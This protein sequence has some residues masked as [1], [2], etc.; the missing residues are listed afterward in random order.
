MPVTVTVYDPIDMLDEAVS[1]SVLVKVGV[2][3]GGSKLLSMP[4][5]TVAI[6]V[7][8]WADPL[9]GVT[10]IVVDPLPP[11]SIGRLGGLADIEK[12]KGAALTVSV[13]VVD[14]ESPPPVPVMV[15]VYVPVGVEELV[16][17][18]MLPEAVGELGLIVT[19]L[20]LK[21][22]DA[23]EGKPEAERLTDTDEL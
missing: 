22:A 14:F 4:M 21:L 12:S 10:V 7:T 16:V 19:E 15:I 8:L 2:P 1:V 20:G 5:G 17:I 6:N 11:R 3:Y 13:Y 23:P 18:V 9:T